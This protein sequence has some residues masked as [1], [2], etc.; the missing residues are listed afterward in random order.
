MTKD[1][2][3]VNE[4]I[5]RGAITKEEGKN[6]RQKNVLMQAIGVEMDIVPSIQKVELNGKN[7]LICSDGLFNSLE[8]QRI[9]EIVKKK[10]I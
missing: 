7:I 1:H 6:H 9:L 5:E 4:L 2:T 10:W 3:L 8:D